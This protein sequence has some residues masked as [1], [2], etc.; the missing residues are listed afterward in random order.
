M[1][2][3]SNKV[4]LALVQV[5]LNYLVHDDLTLCL[6]HVTHYVATHQSDFLLTNQLIETRQ[7]EVRVCTVRVA[8]KFVEPSEN[9]RF[10]LV[11]THHNEV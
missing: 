3:L 9:E 8:L 1:V 7:D 2:E 5:I 6:S 10:L 4:V 11:L